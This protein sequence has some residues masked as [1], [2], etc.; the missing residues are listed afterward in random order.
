MKQKRDVDGKIKDSLWQRF[1]SWR[2]GR[3]IR[4]GKLPRGR[5]VTA[6]QVHASIQNSLRGVMAEIWGVLSARKL[7]WAKNLLPEQIEDLLARETADDLA[8]MG[9]CEI[10]DLGV[11]SVKKV[12]TAF[13][14]YM[15]DSLQ[16]SGTYPLS[17][18]RYHGCGTG[19]T[20]EANT[21][22]ALTTEVGSRVAGTQVEGA[23]ANI[24]RTVAT[25]TPGGTYA[26]TEHGIFTAASAGT[27]MDRSLF[28][29]INVNPTD[30]I[31]FTYECTFNAEA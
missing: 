1:K 26:I 21:Q 14:D 16:N 5:V 9:Y 23:S 17:N 13:R 15:V 6:K 28:S 30:S 18:F 25:I 22:T 11:I 27:L 10:V 29:A 7:V 8:R 3:K 24:Y 2:L 12:T 31:E 19:T 4:K 20:A